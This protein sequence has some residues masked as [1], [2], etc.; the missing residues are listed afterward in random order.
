MRRAQARARA[1]IQGQA[2]IHYPEIA[3]KLAALRASGFELPACGAAYLVDPTGV[4]VPVGAEPDAAAILT[5][6]ERCLPKVT[7]LEALGDVRTP[8][9]AP[10]NQVFG[11]H[12]DAAVVARPTA[13]AATQTVGALVAHV[14]G[15]HG[16]PGAAVVHSTIMGAR[17]AGRRLTLKAARKP[18]ESAGRRNGHL[19]ENP[20][21]VAWLA[22]PKTLIALAAASPRRP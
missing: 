17:I 21:H 10:P 2:L 3:A 14:H 8:E 18:P 9:P 12:Q 6:G 22:M 5:G 4:R 13:C 20:E 1:R 19:R 7:R 15:A 11:G 16:R